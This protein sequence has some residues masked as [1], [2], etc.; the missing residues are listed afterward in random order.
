MELRK[1]GEHMFQRK[2]LA[3]TLALI[4]GLFLAP[5]SHAQI[6]DHHGG[7]TTVG[8]PDGTDHYLGDGHTH[9]AIGSQGHFTGDGHNHGGVPGTDHQMGDGHT[10]NAV[11][12]RGHFSGDGHNHSRGHVGHDHGKLV[13]GMN[14]FSVKGVVSVEPTADPADA[15][16]PLTMTVTLQHANRPLKDLVDTDVDFT[17]SPN[18]FVKVSGVG[19]GV[20]EDI[21]LGDTVKIMGSIVESTDG[22]ANIYEAS[23]IIIY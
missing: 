5:L 16:A 18:A 21:M 3:I 9:N 12:T 11:G 20:V 10:H 7:G 23:Q 13:R 6:V 4:L 1:T 8:N 19:P 17:I 14:R 2:L 15:T 22:A